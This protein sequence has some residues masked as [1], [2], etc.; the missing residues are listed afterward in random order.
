MASTPNRIDPTA[1]PATTPEPALHPFTAPLVPQRWLPWASAIVGI[2]AVLIPLVPPGPA[3]AVLS[4][5]VG[6]GTALG[7]VSNGVKVTKEPKE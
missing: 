4:I 1:A 7:I 3:Q 2:C 5:I 6:L